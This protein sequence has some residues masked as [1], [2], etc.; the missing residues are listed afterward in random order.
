MSVESSDN[1][2]AVQAEYQ[3]GKYAF[4]RGEYRRSVEH[5]EQANSLVAANSRLGGE[6]QI[7]LATAY[8]AA[9]RHQ[10]AI[11]LC[12]QASRHPHYETR[13]QGKRLLYILQAPQLATRPEW[14]TQIPDLNALEE[15]A[16]QKVMLNRTSRS[17]PKQPGYQLE[18]VDLN[19]VNTQDNRFIWVAL[20]TVVVT[21]GC[22]MW[23]S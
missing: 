2:D 1:L 22:L 18:S 5:L 8:Q 9:G 20:I 14:L 4:E 12:Q 11:A 16:S 19:Q 23:F 6:V 17:M 21:L 7:W 15:G 3:A 13:Q 10:E